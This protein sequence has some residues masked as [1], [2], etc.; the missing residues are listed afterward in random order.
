[1]HISVDEY[2]DTDPLQH[3]MV[4]RLATAADSFFLVGDT[5]QSIY[6]FRGSTMEL[7]ANFTREYPATKVVILHDNYRSTVPILQAV[8]TLISPIEV[9]FRSQLRSNVDGPCPPVEVRAFF[10]TQSEVAATVSRI[11]EL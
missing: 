3:D 10:N 4:T 9:P 5:D 2:Q 11:R 8:R 6:S 1:R 7:M